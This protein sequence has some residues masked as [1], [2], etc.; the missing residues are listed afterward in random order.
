MWNPWKEFSI[1]IYFYLLKNLF[2][3]S[4]KIG[5]FFH[6]V[7]LLDL[8]FTRNLIF[9]TV[10]KSKLNQR[11]A[12]FDAKKLKVNL[13]ARKKKEIK[14]KSKDSEINCWNN[15]NWIPN[16]VNYCLYIFLVIFQ[17]IIRLIFI[18]TKIKKCFV[19]KILLK[20]QSYKLISPKNQQNPFKQN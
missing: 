5:S 16:P 4:M 9:L 10:R 8:S 15:R 13:I 18:S 19:S 20:D 2:R 7:W 11:K 6:F 12:K 14:L 3:C 17:K 1:W